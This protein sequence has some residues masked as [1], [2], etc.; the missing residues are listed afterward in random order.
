MANAYSELTDAA[1]QRARFD[2]DR[3]LYESLYGSAPPV[4]E[5]FL[6]SL[7]FLPACAGGALWFDRVVM[8]AVGAE[9]IEDVLWAPVT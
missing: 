4:D 2:H 6:A 7:D 9:K 5:D 3:A 8:L 1:E